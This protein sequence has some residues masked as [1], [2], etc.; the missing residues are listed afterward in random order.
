MSNEAAIPRTVPDRRLHWSRKA[1]QWGTMAIA[2][3]IPLSGLF[4]IDPVEGAF[5]ILDRQIWFS[6]FFIVVGF[7]M[8]L[9]CGLVLTYSAL[10]N[11]FCGWSCPQ[12]TLS[13]WAN[14][15]THKWLGKHA[16]VS[17][18]GERMK[19]SRGKKKWLNWAV[20]LGLL[21]GMSMLLAL[22]PML[23]FL[24][25][26][27]I[28]AFVTLQPDD[29]LPASMY[30][31]YS[32][33]TLIILLDIG[34][35]RHFWCRFMCIYGVWQ[36]SFKTR[37]TLH[38]AHDKSHADECARCNFCVSSCITRIDPRQT[39]TYDHCVNCG[40]CIVACNQVRAAR[41]GGK[42]LL[43][44]E[45]GERAGQYVDNMKSIGPLLN[46]FKAAIPLAL[47]GLAMFVWGLWQY[48]PYHMTAYRADTM[49][50]DQ[51]LDYR[52]MVSNKRYQPA[53]LKVSVLG[54]PEN[55]YQLSRSRVV[56]ESAGKQE[57]NIRLVDLPKGLYSM[58]IV[59]TSTDGWQERFL[60]RHFAGA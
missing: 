53:E 60:L 2:V 23:Y 54:L 25:P 29:R 17:L 3:L 56:F 24:E 1:V 33:F 12:N 34:L 57:V 38:I 47:L 11:A 40:E 55:S 37:E 43:R 5:I 10:G 49:Q 30:W 4:R 16:E 7:W 13:E 51:I 59:V 48:Q 26:S 44:F 28:G 21:V 15:M 8:A 27:T 6:D 50:G 22:V 36:H 52:V 31:I 9:S 45:L 39:E 42:S 20:F 41:N 19:V 46:R 18:E 58:T 32:M 35:I 14:R